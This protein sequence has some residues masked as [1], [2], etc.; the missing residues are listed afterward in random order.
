MKIIYEVGDIV[1]VE[2]NMEVPHNLGASTVELKNLVGHKKWNVYV[3]DGWEVKTG[4]KAV[5]DE[6]WMIP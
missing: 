5:L 4:T 1:E 6:K 2:D 3:I